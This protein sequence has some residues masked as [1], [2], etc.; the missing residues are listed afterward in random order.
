MVQWVFL[1]RK[2]KKISRERRQV[3]H[4]QPLTGFS[5]CITRLIIRSFCSFFLGLGILF[6]S[7][8][9]GQATERGETQEK[10]SAL[11]VPLP[12]PADFLYALDSLPLPPPPRWSFPK[13]NMPP[14]RKLDSGLELGVFPGRNRMGE[15]LEMVILRIDP[16]EY[17]FTVFTVSAEGES[18]SLGEWAKRHE[19]VAVINA[20][21]YL[22]DG[23]TSTGY[24]RSGT[25]VNNSR[26]VSKFGAFF[27]ADPDNDSLPG[28]ALLDRTEDSW[29]TLLPRYRMVVQNYRLISADRRLLW[30]PGG[31]QHSIAAIGRDGS[32]AILFIH[33]REPL[34]GVDFGTL[35]LT[36]PI[37]VRV[38]M[39]AEGG[40]QAGLFVH[41]ANFQQ[42]WMGRH[43][44][45]FWSSGNQHA[46]LPNVIGIRRRQ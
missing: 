12:N 21:M 16:R 37:D 31:P 8:G 29:E 41:T 44:A 26:I 39:Y 6:G 40:S 4:R 38:V 27:V 7:F 34:T 14:W 24:L 43:P 22:P 15:A 46:V 45:D 28:A 33:C 3:F 25:F 5:L 2:L 17:A 42:T 36:L 30:S 1:Y 23:R 13:E 20:S 19:L 9:A 11:T 35:L 18:L 32:G 10:A